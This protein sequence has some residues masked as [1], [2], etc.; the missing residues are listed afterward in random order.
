[1]TAVRVHA[2]LATARFDDLSPTAPA[3]G[4]FPGRGYVAAWHRVRAPGRPPLLVESDDALLPLVADEQGTLTFAGEPDLTDYHSP[5]GTGV[6]RLAKELPRL[7]PGRRF[8]F[9]SLPEEAA[10]PLA[11]GL[12]AGGAEVDAEQH[13][14]TAVLPLP[15][16]P[17]A[18]L[19]SIGKKHRHEIRRKRRRFHEEVGAPVLE[20]RRGPAA[21]EL[22]FAMHRRSAGEKGHFMT[23]EMERFFAALDEIP[24]AIIDTLV[25]AG[26]PVAAVFSFETEDAYYLYNSAY[27]PAVGHASPGVVLVSALIEDRIARGTRIFDFLKGDEPYKFRY[28]ARPRPLF[29]LEGRFP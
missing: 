17:E 16:T 21:L 22:F 25:V 10:R 20:R 5:L 1:V 4:P 15:P 24:G 2:D 9:D 27:D 18:W 29:L 26:T 14:L 7:F 28:G 11:R 13:H 3:T 6:A 12:R 8:H 23:R 19:A